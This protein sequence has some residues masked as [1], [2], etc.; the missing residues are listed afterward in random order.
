MSKTNFNSRTPERHNSPELE[1]IRNEALEIS[2]KLNSTNLITVTSSLGKEGNKELQ[3]EILLAIMA[4]RGEVH[5]A[6]NGETQSS[7]LNRLSI[8]FYR[9]TEPVD[10]HRNNFVSE[11]IA[12]CCQFVQFFFPSSILFVLKKKKKKKK[13]SLPQK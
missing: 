3:L 9:K 8:Y 6:L 5:Y 2:K 7:L 12:D 10:Q 11:L 1:K 13:S 4:K